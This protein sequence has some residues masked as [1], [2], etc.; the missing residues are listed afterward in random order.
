MST[1]KVFC[2]K[3]MYL[4]RDNVG[5]FSDPVYPFHYECHSPYNRVTH[6]NWYNDEGVSYEKRPSELNRDND[7]PWFEER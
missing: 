3:C 7:C 5:S 4:S 2:K 1:N 6:I